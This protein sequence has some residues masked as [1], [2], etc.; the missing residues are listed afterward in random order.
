MQC[1]WRNPLQK[2]L[3]GGH[4][5]RNS[6]SSQ[7]VSEH[8]GLWHDP[9][10]P[11]H[12]SALTDVTLAANSTLVV[13]SREDGVCWCLNNG[14]IWKKESACLRGKMTLFLL[15]WQ[16]NFRMVFL[17]WCSKQRQRGSSHNSNKNSC[18]SSCTGT[19]LSWATKTNIQWQRKLNGIE[20]VKMGKVFSLN[21][22]VIAWK[23]HWN[24]KVKAQHEA[25]GCGQTDTA[26]CKHRYHTLVRLKT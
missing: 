22:L 12:G 4:W 20:I 19:V 2:R 26:V 3:F 16:R 1:N 5:G 25:G 21:D 9:S 23:N 11:P 7:K 8:C 10:L 24:E 15:L 17:Q 18:K 14:H 13:A 6:E